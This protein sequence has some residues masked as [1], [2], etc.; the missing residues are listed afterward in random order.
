[1]DYRSV[2]VTELLRRMHAGESE[3]ADKLV[4]L[5]YDDLRRIA[6]LQL[7][8]ERDNHTLQPTA[9][10]H[11]VFIRLSAGQNIDWQNRAHFF[12]VASRVMRRILV[13][14]ARSCKS[15][16]RGGPL[17]PV[18]LDEAFQYATE[19]SLELLA[20][21]DALDQLAKLSP[22]QSRGVE[23]RFFGGLREE[24]IAV[25]QGVSLRTVKRDWRLARAWLS[26]QLQP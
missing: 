16:K 20:L 17:R 10:V 5:I 2:N 23:M 22:R 4:P 6:A 8:R 15:L 25:L 12:A 13:D 18:R 11:E 14:H 21:D 19:R 1:M 24:E 9:I 26:S 3:A 7:R